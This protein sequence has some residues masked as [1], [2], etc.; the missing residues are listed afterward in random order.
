MTVAELRRTMPAKEFMEW[1]IY[2]GV[3]AQEMQLARR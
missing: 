2:Y 3:R 1:G